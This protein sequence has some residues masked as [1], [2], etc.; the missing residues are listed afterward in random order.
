MRVGE[1]R[2]VDMMATPVEDIP[3]F[4]MIRGMTATLVEDTPRLSMIWDMATSLLEDIP[5]LS[6][7]R[8]MATSLVEDIPRL[9][10]IQDEMTSVPATISGGLLTVLQWVVSRNLAV[11]PRD[12][13]QR[14]DTIVEVAGEVYTATGLTPDLIH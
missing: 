2:S 12:I 7:I 10:M 8:D 1:I 14:A 9:S 11:V 4:S 6:V 3:R 5:R 13:I